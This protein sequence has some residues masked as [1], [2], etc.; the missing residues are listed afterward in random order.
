MTSRAQAFE[1]WKQSGS[2]RSENG[3]APCGAAMSRVKRMAEK[4]APTTISVL[5]LGECGVGKDVLARSIHE[6]SPRAEKRFLPVNCGAIPESLIASD[7][8]GYEPG[9][10]TGAMRT[11]KMGLLESANGGTVFL[12][13]IGDLPLSTQATLLR[14]LET[15]ELRPVMSVRPRF[16]DVRF[17]AAT[18]KDLK[19]AV[20]RGEF[21]RDLLHRLNTLTLSVPP[22]RERVD[23]IPYLARAFVEAAWRKLGKSGSP[24]LGPGLLA[25]LVRHQWPGNVRELKNLMECAA[26]LSDGAQIGIEDLPSCDEPM[27]PNGPP[28]DELHDA[29]SSPVLDPAESEELRRIL[30]ALASCSGNQTRAAAMLRV[31]RRTLVAKLDRYQIP[32]PQKNYLSKLSASSP[33]NDTVGS[34]TEPP[35]WSWPP[36]LSSHSPGAA[37]RLP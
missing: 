23:E 27:E 10:F 31:S 19:V 9:A 34:L 14:V 2:A 30:A 4:V 18:N 6:Q 22:L 35:P 20:A 37:V 12:D 3:Y 13:E 29:V 25:R 17:I 7:L 26:A 16:V 28:V 21:R 1:E 33:R 15:G 24:Q 11:G 36:V 8:F 5:I 32:R